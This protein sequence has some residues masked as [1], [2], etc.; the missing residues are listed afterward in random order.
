MDIQVVSSA[1]IRRVNVAGGLAGAEWV[2]AEEDVF[3]T[4]SGAA[5]VGL[6]A[7]FAREFVA[8][9]VEDEFP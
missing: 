7:A 5:A 3:L 8:G 6:G 9:G 4:T 1:R 2:G